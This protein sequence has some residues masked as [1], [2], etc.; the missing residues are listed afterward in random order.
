MVGRPFF[1]RPRQICYAPYGKQQGRADMQEERRIYFA[2]R[3]A[4]EQERAEQSSDPVAARVHRELQ[5]VYVERASVGER[6]PD[7]QAIG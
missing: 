5:R 3:A 2:L 1:L 6:L 4:E 7:K